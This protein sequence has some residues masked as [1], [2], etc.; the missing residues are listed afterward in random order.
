MLLGS[1][2]ASLRQEG[3]PS[4]V[5]VGVYG[6]SSSS[7][8]SLPPRGVQDPVPRAQGEERVG[9]RCP[10]LRSAPPRP[11]RQACFSRSLDRAPGPWGPATPGPPRPAPSLVNGSSS[12]KKGRP[13]NLALA[14]LWSD[15]YVLDCPSFRMPLRPPASASRPPCLGRSR[16][17][18]TPTALASP[19]RAA[20][21]GRPCP[22]APQAR[23]GP[24]GR[25]RLPLHLSNGFQDGQEQQ[26]TAPRWQRAAI[27]QRVPRRSHS[28]PIRA[29]SSWLPRLSGVPAVE[30]ALSV[31]RAVLI[32]TLRRLRHRHLRRPWAYTPQVACPRPAPDAPA[33]GPGPVLTTSLALA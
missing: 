25:P 4:T 18:P 6:P 13:S 10:A 14:H 29:A 22:R 32:Y 17:A 12:C 3:S 9:R 31:V 1:L 27:E 7:L 11:G 23:S 8:D 16:A 19:A 28:A 5:P 15:S 26:R 24:L 20:A 30:P 2:L 33:P 21:R